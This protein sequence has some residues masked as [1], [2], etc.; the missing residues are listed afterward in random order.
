MAWRL[1]DAPPPAHN[2]CVMLRA[3]ISM[4]ILLRIYLLFGAAG[5][6]KCIETGIC[7][8]DGLLFMEM[9][10]LAVNMSKTAVLDGFVWK[11]MDA[12]EPITPYVCCVRQ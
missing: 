10:H 8:I 1:I 2:F 11:P 7:Y 12:P 6:R 5:V 9:V 3:C 4:A